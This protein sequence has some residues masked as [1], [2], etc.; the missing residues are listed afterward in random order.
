MDNLRKPLTLAADAGRVY[1]LGKD[2]NT[3]VK[4]K[5]DGAEVDNQ[6]AITEWWLDANA[7]GVEQHIHEA[8]DELIY[9]LAGPVSV[10]NGDGWQT[11]ETG[12]IA[13]IPAGTPHGFRNDSDKRVGIL[14]ILMGGAYEAMM[15]QIQAMFANR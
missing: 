3:T 8:N 6:Y 5:A 14:N 2:N 11:L 12:A 13:I 9:V 4:F 1:S 10:M 7:P 15:P